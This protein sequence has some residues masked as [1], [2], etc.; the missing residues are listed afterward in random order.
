VEQRHEGTVIEQLRLERP[1][2]RLAHGRAALSSS[3]VEDAVGIGGREVA[4]QLARAGS[5]QRVRDVVRI[6]VVGVPPPDEQVHGGVVL[7]RLE[8][9]RHVDGV[10]LHFD[11]QVGPGVEQGREQR[12]RA[13]AQQRLHRRA[14][15]HRLRQPG[16]AK[17]IG[18][19]LPA[20]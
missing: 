20:Q 18:R 2:E 17:Q 10:G 16:R 4:V 14:E 3:V 9:S 5:E 12:L 19:F 7:P 1:V 8:I 6:V 15:P 11:P 13:I